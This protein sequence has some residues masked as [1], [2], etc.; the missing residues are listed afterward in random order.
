VPA[1]A[2]VGL[3]M[4]D[5]LGLVPFTSGAERDVQRVGVVRPRVNH[6]PVWHLLLGED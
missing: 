3:A 1:D 6:L 4:V 2:R 5:Q